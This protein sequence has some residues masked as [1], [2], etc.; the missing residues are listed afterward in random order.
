M[1]ILAFFPL[2]RH[3][4]GE[5]PPLF[6]LPLKNSWKVFLGPLMLERR[7]HM[8]AGMY[9]GKTMVE[10]KEKILLYDCQ[11]IKADPGIHSHIK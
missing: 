1:F 8:G 11:I 9:S 10:T 5:R 2:S 3:R 6:A 7:I 4:N